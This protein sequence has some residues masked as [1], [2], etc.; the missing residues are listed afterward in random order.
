MTIVLDRGSDG[1]RVHAFLI[2][3]GRYRHLA[4]GEDPVRHGLGNLRQLTSPPIS[5]VKIVEWLATSLNHP[6]AQLGTIDVLLSPPQDIDAG[7]GPIRV[8]KP[9][10]QTV[11]RTFNGWK[12][13][14]DRSHENVAVFYFCG[15]GA[16]GPTSQHLFLED[17]CANLNNKLENTIDFD[18][19]WRGMGE[20]KAKSQY[21]FID[22]CRVANQELRG[23]FQSGGI[24]LVRRSGYFVKE[25]RVDHG[26]L[27]SAKEGAK[28]FGRENKISYFT[29]ALLE[30]LQGWGARY[31]NNRWQVDLSEINRHVTW[32]VSTPPEDKRD[33]TR[34]QES[35]DL[36]MNGDPVL[37]LPDEP[38]L[39]VTIKC[40]PAFAASRAHLTVHEQNNP[41]P[42]KSRREVSGPWEI[43]LPPGSYY[44]RVT[45]P[46]GVRYKGADRELA[47][48][49]PPPPNSFEVEVEA[50][51]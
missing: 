37:H 25:S 39:P 8:E 32:R 43:G 15:H 31:L 11:R 49:M 19:S 12:D 50:D 23:E 10:A 4:G 3:V 2:G 20:C 18:A 42:K 51:P 5:T 48:W 34:W 45:F 36:F 47:I 29:E 28:S 26:Y 9:D 46:D 40:N 44:L 13:R 33:R 30:A 6:T 14:C 41:K 22:A 1:P 27:M 16:Q 21:F 17:F 24:I 7:D 38:I 35:P